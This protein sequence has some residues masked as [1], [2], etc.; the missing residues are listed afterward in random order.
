MI[1]SG[2]R[3][4][5]FEHGELLAQ[6]HSLQCKPVAWQKERTNIRHHW[7][8]QAHCSDN[9]ASVKIETSKLSASVF[10]PITF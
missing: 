1:E 9:S 2:A 5:A 10:W 3:L 4:L 8:E 6:G 7:N